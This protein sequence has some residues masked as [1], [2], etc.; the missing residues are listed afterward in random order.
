[1]SKRYMDKDH[2][3]LMD[4][5]MFK[6]LFSSIEARGIITSLISCITGIPS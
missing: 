2:I 4:D 6:T 1:M 3:N 5:N